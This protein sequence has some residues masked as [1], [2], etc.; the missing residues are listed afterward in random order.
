MTNRPNQRLGAR[1]LLVIA[2]LTAAA[3]AVL[4]SAHHHGRPPASAPRSTTSARAHQQPTPRSSATACPGARS[5]VDRLLPFDR[6][7]LRA[8]VQL[9][10]R[11]ATAYATRTRPSAYLQRLKPLVTPSLYKE[12]ARGTAATGVP[13]QTNGRLRAVR[14][15]T[16]GPTSVI[17]VATATLTPASG[18]RA[19]VQ[20]LPL[21]ITVTATGA[22]EPLG[23]EW[24][25]VVNSV[26][27]AAEGDTGD[28]ADGDGP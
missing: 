17:V 5:D 8:A 20:T 25:W 26:Q 11:F 24:A 15:R 9:A 2:G 21:A 6:R 4:L 16:I 18:S 27:P 13:H 28:S 10:A 7:G 19:R 22:D 3:G 14:T 1:P 23:R 12:I